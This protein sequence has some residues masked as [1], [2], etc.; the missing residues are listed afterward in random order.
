MYIGGA[1]RVF[2]AHVRARTRLS[3]L[4]FAYW[5]KIM[6]GART[7]C[8]E[9]AGANRLDSAHVRAR[10][11]LSATAPFFLFFCMGAPPR[12]GPAEALR[13]RGCAQSILGARATAAPARVHS[14]RALGTQFIFIF[15]LFWAHGQPR[16]L[17]AC[18]AA[19]S[20]V[21]NLLALLVQEFKN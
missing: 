8:A 21:L 6:A 14:R 10:T 19:V 1:K 16:L 13:S 15:I 17:R 20:S 11:R 2:S 5:Y 9:V 18:I 3:N 12:G 7:R 4:L